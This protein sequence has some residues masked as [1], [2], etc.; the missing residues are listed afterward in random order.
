MCTNLPTMLLKQG[1]KRRVLPCHLS[2]ANGWSPLVRRS[3]V[4]GLIVAPQEV[5]GSDLPAGE[6]PRANP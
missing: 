3:V 2:I 4:T 6:I 5:A 1:K